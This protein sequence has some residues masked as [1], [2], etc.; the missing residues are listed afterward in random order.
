MSLSQREESLYRSAKPYLW[1]KFMSLVFCKIVHCASAARG[2]AGVAATSP[3]AYSLQRRTYTTYWGAACA[4]EA[5]T[6]PR[7]RRPPTSSTLPPRHCSCSSLWQRRGAQYGGGVVWRRQ[8]PAAASLW[9][10]SAAATPASSIRTSTLCPKFCKICP[11]ILRQFCHLD[12]QNVN[13]M[14]TANIYN[15]IMTL[16][17]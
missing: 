17:E 7:Q 11:T 12:Q 8:P 4:R 10:A 13:W 9:T 1:D 14:G 5:T 6:T 3:Q 15:Q 16:T 2:G